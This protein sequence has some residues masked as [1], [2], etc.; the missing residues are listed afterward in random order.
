MKLQAFGTIASLTAVHAGTESPS[1]S[2]VWPFCFIKAP[3]PGVLPGKAD[4]SSVNRDPWHPF[5]S[6]FS[7]AKE[8]FAILKT[9]K[10][11]ISIIPRYWQHADNRCP[12]ELAALRPSWA[13]CTSNFR[14]NGTAADSSHDLLQNTRRWL[15][16]SKRTPFDPGTAFISFVCSESQLSSVRS[17]WCGF[18]KFPPVRVTSLAWQ[19]NK[20][21][22]RVFQNKAFVLGS[23]QTWGH[24]QPFQV[25]LC[26]PLWIFGTWVPLPPLRHHVLSGTFK[27]QSHCSLN[28]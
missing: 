3:E 11:P 5:Q 8:L 26:S 22:Q 10:I 27:L 21:F 20:H 6:K 13:V 9:W 16:Y 24:F 19:C 14:R 28:V 7:L 23:V 25:K 4:V 15:S 12:Q 18:T 2:A 17:K 1:P